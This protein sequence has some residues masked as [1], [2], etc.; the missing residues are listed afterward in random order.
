MEVW[1]DIPGYEGK[2]QVSNLGNVKSLLAWN[3]RYKRHIRREKLLK[4]R[5]A[6]CGYSYCVL[7]DFDGGKKAVRCHRIVAKTFVP[8]PENKAE[9]NHINGIKT[10]NRVE[11]LEW[12]STSENQSHAVANGLKKTKP[13]LQYDRQG[14]LVKE[15]GS[16]KQIAD[17]FCCH[18]NT[19]SNC[20]RG[21]KPTAYGYIWRYKEA[22]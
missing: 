18:Q 7:C 1:K 6:K 4:Q 14:N 13:V 22:E 16:A 9:V 21:V 15:W 8:N 20:C 5:I 3:G 19:I 2:Y 11:N 10:D 17:A 12:C